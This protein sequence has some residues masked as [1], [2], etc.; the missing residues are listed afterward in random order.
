[1]EFDEEGMVEISTYDVGRYKWTIKNFSKLYHQCKDRKLFS[2]KFFVGIHSWRILLRTEYRDDHNQYYLTINLCPGGDNDN[3]ALHDSC[4]DWCNKI[5]YT[6][7]IFN[8][9]DRN[10]KK[11]LGTT[12][13]YC[14]EFLPC[15]RRK[16]WMTFDKFYN[17]NNGFLVNDTCIVVAEVLNM[18]GPGLYESLIRGML[19]VPSLATI[20]S[21]DFK[22]LCKIEKHFVQLL[23]ELFLT[24]RKSKRSQKYIEWSFT[25]LERVLHF[26]KTNSVKDMNDDACKELQILWEELKTFGFDELSWINFDL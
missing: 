15:G 26:L 25:A 13:Q 14:D 21:V 9:L 7:S 5:K 18:N 10:M 8:Q 16:F 12:Y 6:I 1:M 3:A 4:W 19:W 24:H 20:S 2:Q 11:T 23:G 17:P 22:G